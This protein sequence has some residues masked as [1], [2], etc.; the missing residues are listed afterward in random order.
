MVTVVFPKV[1]ALLALLAGLILLLI[2]A[3]LLRWRSPG[4]VDVQEIVSQRDA[5]RTELDNEDE[6]DDHSTGR[7]NQP[8]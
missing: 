3:L 5:A 1:S 2:V 6:G 7:P 4:T 8:R